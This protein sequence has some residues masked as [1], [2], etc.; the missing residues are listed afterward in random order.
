MRP[1]KCRYCQTNTNTEDA[2]MTMIGKLKAYFCNEE[3]YSLFIKEKEEKEQKQEIARQEKEE[4][5][6]VVKQNKEF[7]DKV[8]YL[9]CEII[10]RKEIINTMLWKEWKTW[11]KVATNERIGQYLEENKSALM[12]IISGLNNNELQRIMYFSAILKNH[13]GDF[14]P[15]KIY[16][17]TEKPKIQINEVFYEPIQTRNNKRRSL[18]DLEDEF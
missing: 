10:G 15:I 11:N 7:K 14:K 6:L 13:L 12:H 8:Y 4:H 5:A 9:I 1:C 17:P 3:H 18:E 2:Y 16:I